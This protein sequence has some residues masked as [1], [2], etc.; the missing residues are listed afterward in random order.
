MKKDI[1]I[2]AL[3]GLIAAFAYWFLALVGGRTTIIGVDT[4]G[5]IKAYIIFICVFLGFFFI[6][7]FLQIKGRI[8]HVNSIASAI[9]NVCFL[10]LLCFLSYHAIRLYAPIWG[11]MVWKLIMILMAAFSTLVLFVTIQHE[12]AT[13]SSLLKNVLIGIATLLL[14]LVWYK[15]V[16]TSNVFMHTE[17][18]GTLYNVH[19]SSAY[20][21]QIYA[22]F[23]AVPFMGG[24]ADQYGHYG[25]FFAPVMRLMGSNVHSIAKIIGLLAALSAVLFMYSAFSA[26]SKN[27][28]KIICY[29]LL[30][31]AGAIPVVNNIYWQ[32]YPHRLIMPSIVM[33]YVTFIA[34]KG[35]K[36]AHFIVGTVL[37]ILGVVWSSDSGMVAL[38]CWVAFIFALFV[39]RKGANIRSIFIGAFIAI[40]IVVV[41]V[42]VSWEIV[43]IYNYYVGGAP[44]TIYEYFGLNNSEY[45]AGLE[46]SLEFWN[47]NHTFKI[48]ILLY[49]FSRS[50][51][52][53]IL[54]ESE[55]KGV[56]LEFTASIMA[57]G[58]STYYIHNTNAGN[59]TTNLFYAMCLCSIISEYERN[60]TLSGKGLKDILTGDFG[61]ILSMAI[62]VLSI[63][64]TALLGIRYVYYAEKMT[65]KYN[66]DAYD[67][68]KF[69]D[70]VQEIK[71]TIDQ[72]TAGVGIGTSAIFLEMGRDRGTYRYGI[73]DVAFV[74]ESKPDSFIIWQGYND[75]YE[76]YKPAKRF[77]IDQETWIYYKKI[78]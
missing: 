19:H 21:D 14:A 64:L 43:N 76:G 46:A 22:V 31:F 16:E 66:S 1:N 49:C 38:L 25:L 57:L 15:S 20:I 35:I 6:T 4:I 39:K 17:I 48:I 75:S 50:F 68:Y 61:R 55:K 74:E 3:F 37:C 27:S 18:Y 65:L 58:L 29:V 32:T 72:D 63:L 69:T 23:H 67:Y 77:K 36:K 28:S 71:E 9:I 51:M 26:L 45:L 12:T 44:L 24:Q 2:S 11:G 70:S 54:N 5:N 52:G 62:V 41:S 56:Y 13:I 78:E 73:E 7:Y 10:L 34:S 59:E 53:I 47:M 8:K 42:L 60:K 33:A 40:G 30:L